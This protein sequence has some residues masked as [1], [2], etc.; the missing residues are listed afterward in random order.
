MYKCKKYGKKFKTDISDIV[1]KNSNFTHEFKKNT[2][3]WLVYSSDQSV[4]LPI[5][6]KKTTK[7]FKGIHPE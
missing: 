1:D 7:V 3:N 2:L 4:K 6:L 5:K